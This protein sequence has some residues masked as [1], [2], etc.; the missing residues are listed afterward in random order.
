MNNFNRKLVKIRNWKI[1]SSR[2]TRPVWELLRLNFQTRSAIQ[3]LIFIF[4]LMRLDYKVL[5]NKKI[6]FTRALVNIGEGS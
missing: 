2:E 3:Q 5:D 1:P 4:I 6:H